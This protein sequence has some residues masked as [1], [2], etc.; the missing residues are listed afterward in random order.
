MLNLNSGNLTISETK[1]KELINLANE[2]GG[3]HI[4]KDY[5]LDLCDD[6]Y[7]DGRRN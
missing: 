3:I 4:H 6:F 5:L 2:K 1:L 7:E